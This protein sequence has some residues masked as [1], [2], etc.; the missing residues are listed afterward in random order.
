MLIHGIGSTRR[1]WKPVLRAL[2]ERHDAIALSLPG[3]G[4]SPPARGPLTVAALADEVEGA[5]DGLGIGRAHVAGHSLGGWIGAELACRGRARTLVA[6]S[7]AGLWTERERRWC[8]RSLGAS[9]FLASRIS[10]TATARLCTVGPVRAL[11]M[12]QMRARGWRLDPD[13]ATYEVRAFARSSSFEAIVRHFRVARAEGLERV[14]VPTR[15]VWGTWD[16]LLPV[17]QARRWVERIPG[18]E[19][20]ELPRLGHAPMSDDPAAVARTILELTAPRI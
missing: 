9:R 8:V 5:M 1:V 4:E 11:V 16:C 20:V 12:A 7:P 2:E 6:I 14:T 18:A 10:E 13:E 19:L 15:I 3:C 17:R